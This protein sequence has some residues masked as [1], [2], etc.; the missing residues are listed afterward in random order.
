[1]APRILISLLYNSLIYF[2]K[3]ET[4]ETYAR[5][6]LSLIILAVGS[7]YC[8]FDHPHEMILVDE[9]LEKQYQTNWMQ[10]KCWPY[11][12]QLEKDQ[13]FFSVKG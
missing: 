12:L 6:F 7:V 5:A 4:I 3:Y 8:D 10:R 1:M 2:L 11:Y 13:S 9:K